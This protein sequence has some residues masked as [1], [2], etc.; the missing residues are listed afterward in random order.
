MTFRENQ[1]LK[2]ALELVAKAVAGKRIG[3]RLENFSTVEV[4]SGAHS[5]LRVSDVTTDELFKQLKASLLFSEFTN[6]D[7]RIYKE[8]GNGM[9]IR[10]HPHGGGRWLA[11]TNSLRLH[12]LYYYVDGDINK[13]QQRVGGFATK[14]QAQADL[15]EF[16]I[17]YDL[18][19]VMPA[20]FRH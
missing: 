11:G 18:E 17:K 3:L 5:L 13:G 2:K 6:G 16:A 8:K 20:D 14:Q 12:D 10:L 4:Q 15:D 7:E 9:W 1:E 19:M